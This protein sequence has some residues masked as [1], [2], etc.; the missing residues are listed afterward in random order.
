M[1]NEAQRLD[2]RHASD[3]ILPVVFAT[4]TALR[5]LCPLPFKQVGKWALRAG[6]SP[7]RSID[8]S[9]LPALTSLDD[10]IMHTAV[11]TGAN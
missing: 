11:D 5:I 2:P 3:Y 10:L 8:I 4:P 1:I 7:Y 6:H 9:N